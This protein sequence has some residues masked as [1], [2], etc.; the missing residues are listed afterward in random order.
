[1]KSATFGASACHWLFKFK[2]KGYEVFLA[3]MQ[4]VVQHLSSPL[5]PPPRRFSTGKIGSLTNG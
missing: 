1:M 2:S 3:L 4:P 5:P